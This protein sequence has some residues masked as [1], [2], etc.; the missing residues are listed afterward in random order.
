[1][2]PTFLLDVFP[3][4]G[5]PK[6]RSRQLKREEDSPAVARLDFSARSSPS[7][8]TDDA[9]PRDDPPFS[10]PLKLPDFWE[11]QPDAWFLHAESQFVLRRVAD[12]ELRYH[13]VVASLSPTATAKLVGIL[14]AP[15]ATNKYSAIKA[16]LLYA[17]GL[18]D[19]ERADR[20]FALN[21]LG[22]RKP[23]E[24]MSHMLDLVGSRGPEFIL[25]QLFL[26]QLPASVRAAL[27][28]CPADDFTAF[29]AEADKF[30]LEG[31]E[32]GSESTF[33]TYASPARS[34][35]GNKTPAAKM[36]GPLCF[37][38]ERFGERASKCVPP[39]SFTGQGNAQAGA[40]P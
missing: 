7:S 33:R 26:R 14:S 39:C 40:R 12:D 32:V 30:Y 10:P 16:A 25:K 24:L 11:A 15:P 2:T 17:F 22:G 5:M 31:R 18:S 29:A 23:S 35:G 28:N 4:S 6:R 36:R 37:Y 21:G 1:M 38:H 27:A 34:R 3:A 20:L 19:A 13:H 9:G 8:P